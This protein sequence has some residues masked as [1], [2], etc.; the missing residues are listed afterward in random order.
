MVDDESAS[1]SRAANWP[2]IDLSLL[3]P[4]TK[5][6]SAV[7]DVVEPEYLQRLISFVLQRPRK[8]A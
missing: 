7:L 3:G 1:V 8:E 6:E 2:Y 5:F 4:E